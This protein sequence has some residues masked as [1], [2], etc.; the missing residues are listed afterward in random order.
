MGICFSRPSALGPIK[1]LSAVFDFL[2]VCVE[3]C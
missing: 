3:K 2:P 1:F